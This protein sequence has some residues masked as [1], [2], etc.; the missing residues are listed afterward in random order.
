MA[1]VVPEIVV[2]LLFSFFLAVVLW[3]PQVFVQLVNVMLIML[4]LLSD[5]MISRVLVFNLF[6]LVLNNMVLTFL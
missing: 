4:T 2:R 3:S 6:K 5:D 1:V